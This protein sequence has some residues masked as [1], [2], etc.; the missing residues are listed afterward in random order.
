MKIELRRFTSNQRLSQETLCFAA[1]I[2]IDGKKVGDCENRGQGG[3]TSYFIQDEATRKAFEAHAVAV[4]ERFPE[5]EQSE[6]NRI[7]MA[8]EGLLDDLAYK[9]LEN[10]SWQR[11]CKSK[12][13]FFLKTDEPGMY[14]ELKRPFSAEVKAAL[15]KHHGDNLGEIVNER[16]I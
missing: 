3:C 5:Y 12:T 8:A 10:K 4:Y 1:D 11:K 9:L 15:Q 14:R 13:I 7:S 6:H 2:Y 16:F